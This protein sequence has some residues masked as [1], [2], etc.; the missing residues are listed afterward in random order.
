LE[1]TEEAFV[2]QEELEL[3]SSCIEGD[4]NMV[5]ATKTQKVDYEVME[6]RVEA[7]NNEIA[8]L[9][10]KEREHAAKKKNF[11]RMKALSETERVP[12]TEIVSSEQQYFNWIV[13]A[14]KE[15][16]FVRKINI[17]LRATNK[18]LKRKIEDLEIQLTTLEKGLQQ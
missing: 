4:K 7:S 15:A 12:K 11:K 1:R 17:Q 10:V 9:R 6:R 18:G 13:P 16:K 5:P 3:P 14:T 2:V 8:K